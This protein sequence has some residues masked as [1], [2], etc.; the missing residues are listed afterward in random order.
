MPLSLLAAV[1]CFCSDN[2]NDE[3]VRLWREQV[4]IVVVVTFVVVDEQS[5]YRRRFVNF[6]RRAVAGGDIL[7]LISQYILSSRHRHVVI[8]GSFPPSEPKPPMRRQSNPPP[9]PLTATTMRLD[10]VLPPLQLRSQSIALIATTTSHI[11]MA[12]HHHS[13]DHRCNNRIVQVQLVLVHMDNNNMV[14]LL[15]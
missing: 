4:L 12:Q 2:T 8:R 10:G 14:V 3:L 1:R 11:I 13:L 7:S 5:S 6:D 9:C 15:L